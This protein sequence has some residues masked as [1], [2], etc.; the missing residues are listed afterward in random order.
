MD[1]EDN[2]PPCHISGITTQEKQKKEARVFD[3]AIKQVCN[4]YWQDVKFATFPVLAVPIPC[5]S[6]KPEYYTD[7]EEAH[8]C[9][10]G[11]LRNIRKPDNAKLLSELKF[12]VKHMVWRK[13][14]LIFRKC[15]DPLCSHCSSKPVCT[16]TAFEFL[17]RR[18]FIMFEPQE[19]EQHS[20]HYQYMPGDA[21]SEG[22]RSG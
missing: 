18:K 10:Q 4:A 13:N 19:S 12:M 22:E 20:G 21:I 15:E 14:E 5:I 7:Y 3:E 6:D 16:T 1:G 11:P 8:T 2:L 17:K 9:L